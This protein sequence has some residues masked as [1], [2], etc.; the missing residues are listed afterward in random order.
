MST[1]KVRWGI[2]GAGRI[3]HTF[4]S[5]IQHT[6]NAELVA[7]ASRDVE[8]SSTFASQYDVSIALGDYESLYRHPGVDAIYIATPHTHHLEQASMALK[9]G[10]AV[11]CEKPITTNTSECKELFQVAS[12]ENSYLMEAMW[13]HFLPAIQKAKSW[14]EEGKIGPIRHIK[15][16][17][18]YPLP[19]DSTRRE[20]DAN[21][22][23]GCLLEMGIY[24]VGLAWL[25]G[26]G[27]PSAL[28]VV[29]HKAPNG[30]EDDVILTAEHEDYV[31]SLATSFRAKLQNWAY[32][33]GENGYIAIPNFWR[34]DS[35]YRYVLDECV[36]EYRD[37]RKGSGFEFQIE[38]V[39][40]D[41][42]K[43][44][45]QSQVV[46]PEVSMGMQSYMDVIRKRF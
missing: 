37:N 26:S 33:I 2:V 27:L 14:V 22:A 38:S 19:F 20:Y 39:S 21:L 44:L 45:S 12:T 16:D 3:A 23:G 4:A 6:T 18:G 15:A 31:V 46:S 17:F 7:V 1:N 36:E 42:I 35:C 34:A 5:D 43:G 25:F 8:R 11:L 40:N 13:T 24:P 41:L 30:V 10:K 9:S 29:S 32:I 28:S